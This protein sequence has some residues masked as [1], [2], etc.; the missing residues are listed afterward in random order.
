MT[1]YYT[2]ERMKDNIHPGEEKKIGLYPRV[3]SKRTVFLKELI[4]NASYRTTLSKQ[5][6]RT[7]AF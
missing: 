1:V 5:E 3:I 4:E 2:M 6:M 7:D